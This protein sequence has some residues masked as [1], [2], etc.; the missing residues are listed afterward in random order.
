MG[1]DYG[2]HILDF[3]KNTSSVLHVN[4]GLIDYLTNL[5]LYL[6]N[7]KV[8]NGNSGGSSDI[9]LYDIE[10][11]QYIF[12]SSK[13]PKSNDDI[14]NLPYQNIER[15]KYPWDNSMVWEA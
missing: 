4:N 14:K 7:N 13:Y 15:P 3:E 6:T 5:Q 11:E 12:I 2:L 1:T 8:S 9:T 10:K